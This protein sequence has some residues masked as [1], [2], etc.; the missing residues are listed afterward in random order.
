MRGR[1]GVECYVCT[2]AQRETG[3][4]V[5]RSREADSILQRAEGYNNGVAVIVNN[6]ALGKL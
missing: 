6:E 2:E 5:T 1:G 3:G 4:Q